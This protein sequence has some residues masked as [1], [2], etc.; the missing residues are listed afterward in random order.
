MTSQ[1][2]ENADFP[3]PE[4]KVTHITSQQN[5]TGRDPQPR[6]YAQVQGLVL[7]RPLYEYVSDR[8][9]EQ[10]R[11]AGEIIGQCAQLE[12]LLIRKFRT[13]SKIYLE[14]PDGQR[15]EIAYQLP[16]QN[17]VPFRR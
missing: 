5:R 6:V 10:N 1:E 13:G 9:I 17:V 14:S 8:V 3:Q 4:P 2:T 12:L 7:D 16:P 11:D 15:Q